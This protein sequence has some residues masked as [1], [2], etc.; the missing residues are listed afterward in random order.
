MIYTTSLGIILLGS[1]R[2]PLVSRII[3]KWSLATDHLL[4]SSKKMI[5]FLIKLIKNFSRGVSGMVD[6]A[7]VDGVGGVAEDKAVAW[8]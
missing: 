1:I 8:S 2:D 3:G 4:E 5:V 6:L 7:T